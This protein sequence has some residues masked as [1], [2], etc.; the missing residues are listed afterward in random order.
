MK[1]IYLILSAILISIFANSHIVAQEK[2]VTIS[3]TW[4]KIQSHGSNQIAIWIED[5][6]GNYLTT[7]YAT[8]FTADGGYSK[9][10]ISLSEWTTKFGIQNRTK[11]EVDAIS[12]AT[13]KAGKQ[14]LVWNCKDQSN[15]AVP[16]GTYV[17][18]ME[19]NIHNADKMFF[20]GEIKIGGN[21]QT[22]TGEITYSTPEL[23][24]G[25]ILFK[26]VLVEYK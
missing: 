4:N 14:T 13:P 17:V 20:K 26:D 7:L 6:N 2:N 8:H 11:A 18:R 9:R 5:V 3:Y 16:V 21:N 10:P 19:A 1:Q 24:S 15:N 25:D 22:T 23:E 12:G